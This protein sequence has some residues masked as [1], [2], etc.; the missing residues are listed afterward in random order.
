MKE[1]LVEVAAAVVERGDGRFLLAQRPTGK[2][3]A[4]YWEF[5]G[6]K[7][8]AG[9]TPL[10]ALRRELRE[11]L[12]LEIEQAV[13][14]LT[15]IYAYPHATVRLNFLRVMRWRGEPVSRE[16]QAFSWQRPGLLSV[17]PMLPA[18]AA[19]LRALELPLVY[20]ITNPSYGGGEA[21]LSRLD[22][23]LRDG[24]RL[25]QVRDK[26]MPRDQLLEFTREIVTRARRYG[27]KVLLN[28]DP[29]SAAE[30][31]A[32]G[33]HLTASRLATVCKRPTLD[34]CA[35][36]CHTREELQRAAEL[37][38]DFVV[39]GPVVRTPTHPDATPLGWERFSAMVQGAPLPVYALGGLSLRDLSRARQAGAHGI[40]MVRGAWRP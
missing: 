28:A 3:Y 32:D 38:L 20:A 2:V 22:H 18:N 29:E 5:P 36:S 40:A 4:G 25:I 6:G 37:G 27:A 31:G 30:S 33:V 8:E 19:I 13:P 23:A 10:A 34:W 9:E 14:W 35:T 39:L 17:A 15:R 1:K 12:G 26:N 11:E 21:A 16:R 7:I 24:L